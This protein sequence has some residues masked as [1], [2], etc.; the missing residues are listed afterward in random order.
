[1]ASD[2]ASS[3]HGDDDRASGGDEHADEHREIIVETDRGNVK[4]EEYPGGDMSI[5]APL[6]EPAY[7]TSDEAAALRTAFGRLDADKRGDLK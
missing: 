3:G 7:F 4:I 1:M 5:Y 6:N 2:N